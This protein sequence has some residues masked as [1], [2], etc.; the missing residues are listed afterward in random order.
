MKRWA[1]SNMQVTRDEGGFTVAEL[2]VA[3]FVGLVVL[4][5][6]FS[7]MRVQGRSASYQAG[8]ADAQLTGF[9][10]GDLLMQD[11]RMAGYGMLGVPPDAGVPPLSVTTVGS[12]L[13]VTLRGAYSNV[14]TTLAAGAPVGASSI[15]ATSGSFQANNLVLIDSG[16]NAEVKTIASV[17]GAGPVTIALGSALAHSFPQGPS[18]TQLEVVTWTLTNGLL[19]R[20]GAVVG[21]SVGTFG[22]Q[23]VDGNGTTTSSVPTNLRAVLL[24]LVASQ[25]NPLPDQAQPAR[26][27]VATEANLRN[28]AFRFTV[29]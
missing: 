23:Y 26:S 15:S 13:T 22:L 18:V 9:G 14:V 6:S 11:L 16:V 5:I 2:L 1:P 10:A 7:A 25:P 8:L 3:S 21:E 4:G 24:N 17:S 28:L 19:R 12:T 20:N 29:N 27:T